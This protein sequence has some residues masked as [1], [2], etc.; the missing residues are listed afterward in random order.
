MTYLHPLRTQRLNDHLVLDHERYSEWCH[1]PALAINV[2]CIDDNGD[3]QPV[4]GGV[5]D[6]QEGVG[7]QANATH[8]RETQLLGRRHRLQITRTS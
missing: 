6:G 2:E 7:G 4:G 3:V 8:T 5:V 1:L